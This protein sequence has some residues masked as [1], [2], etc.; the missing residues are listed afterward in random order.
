MI[1]S[2]SCKT[3]KENEVPPDSGEQSEVK[4]VEGTQPE[5]WNPNEGSHSSSALTSPSP[6]S[7]CVFTCKI[8]QATV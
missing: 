4:S 3:H 2:K 1:A 8:N 5:V 6:H 7:H